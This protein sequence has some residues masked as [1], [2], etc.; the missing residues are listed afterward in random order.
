M[1]YLL[2]LVLSVQ[3]ALGAEP[4]ISSG[5]HA[6]PVN[7]PVRVA[8]LDNFPPFSF[9]YRGELVGFTV[10]YLDLL[11]RKTGL[12]MEIVRGS[13][14]DIFGRFRRGE[15]EMITAL[16]YSQERTA[17]TLYSDPYY[18]LPTVVYLREEEPHYEGVESLKGMMVGIEKDVFYREYLQEYPSI[19]IREIEDTEDLMRSL[20]FGEVDA[21]I[22]N[23]NI[24]NF[25]IKRY[26]LDNLRLAGRIDISGIEDEDLRFGIRREHPALHRLIQEGMNRVSA[27]E[28]KELQDRWVGFAPEGVKQALLPGE[29]RMLET[30]REEYGGI[31]LAVCQRWYPIDF[32]DAQR[33]H[34]GIVADVYGKITAAHNMP[35][36]RRA[37]GELKESLQALREGVVDVVPAVVPNAALR[38][39]FALTKPYLSLPLVAVTRSEEFILGGLDSL[40]GRSIACVER[41]NLAE[42]FSEQYPDLQFHTVESV[43]SGLKRVREKKDFALVGTIPAL[44]Y[45]IKQ[46]N[47]Y[48]IKVA[49]TLKE[50]LSLAAAIRRDEPRLQALMQKALDSLPPG[51]SAAIVD[52]WL[53]MS[54]EERFDYS[55]LWKVG[56]GA[57]LLLLLFLLWTRK[58]HS[59]NKRITEANHLLE[60]KNRELE[61]L[62]VTNR[63]TGLFN[64]SKLDAELEKEYERFARYGRPFALIL[65]DIDGF[66][67]VNDSLGHLCGDEVLRRIGA[68]IRR[69]VRSTDISGRWGGE[70]FL[71]ICPETD[72]SGALQVAEKLRAAVEQAEF[73]IGRKV[74]MSL[75]VA[76][77]DS[78][79]DSEGLLRRVDERLYLAKY[80]GKNRV[81]GASEEQGEAG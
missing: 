77:A 23:I 80:M 13:W 6:D 35:F 22:T 15:V 46:H 63:L 1:V 24:G 25:M 5:S 8:L 62:S 45:A 50:S 69:G 32:M 67:A 47:F 33:E 37:Y 17:Y 14:A 3:V 34:R 38:A 79:I 78:G 4:A 75:G 73:N 64:R 42:R 31:R 10:D 44:A 81:V 40:G 68:L 52:S 7:E 66:K 71:I 49:A 11:S 54:L 65:G 55:L 56:A 43:R 58:V 21:V 76:E 2:A 48:N 39:E 36:Q 59:Y 26:L 9:L 72:R 29:Y 30:Y 41:G 19:R 27:G 53:S 20:S 60:E 70:E 18:L 57:L 12:E 51:E 61:Y 74:T 28:Y 16:S